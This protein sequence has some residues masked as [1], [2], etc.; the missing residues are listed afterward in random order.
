M[1]AIKLIVLQFQAAVSKVLPQEHDEIPPYNTESLNNLNIAGTS[2]NEN[3]MPASQAALL[4]RN[5]F[6]PGKQC[7]LNIWSH[8]MYNIMVP[9]NVSI[10]L[11]F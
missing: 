2:S 3:R 4:P 9:L 10:K 8:Y 6:G 7:L 1:Y 11:K 5:I